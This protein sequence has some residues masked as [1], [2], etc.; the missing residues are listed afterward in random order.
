MTR[1]ERRTTSAHSMGRLRPRFPTPDNPTRLGLADIRVLSVAVETGARFVRDRLEGDPLD[2]LFGAKSL[3]DGRSA[4]ATC[5]HEEGFRRAIVFHGLSLGSDVHPS[6]LEGLPASDFLSQGAR[7]RLNY[8]AEASTGGPRANHSPLALF[9]AVIAAETRSGCVQIYSGMIAHAEEEVRRRLRMRYGAVLEGEAR[10]Q[11]GFDWSEPLAAALVSGAMA[12][13]L[14]VAQHDPESTF[15][16]GLD[17][18]VEQRF[19]N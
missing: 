6:A 18:H 14:T 2:W 19:A 11:R 16:E 3:F 10:I 9:T 7:K 17:F 15:A 13:V 1:F 4:V 5:R 8:V 12:H